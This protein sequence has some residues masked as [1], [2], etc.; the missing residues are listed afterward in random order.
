MNR[1]QKAKTPN[2]SKLQRV[3][4]VEHHYKNKPQKAP[5][6]K[7]IRAKKEPKN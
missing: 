7:K 2:P 4:R 6:K 5:K 3:L 1:E